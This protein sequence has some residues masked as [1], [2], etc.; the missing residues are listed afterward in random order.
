MHSKA[1]I[2]F[3]VSFYIYLYLVRLK[4]GVLADESA[5]MRDVYW[6]TNWVNIKKK[7]QI[8]IIIEPIRT[9]YYGNWYNILLTLYKVF[10]T[11][12]LYPKYDNNKF[13]KCFKFLAQS[14]D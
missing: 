3:I 6:H 1:N 9:S 10:S 14:I 8:K 13:F 2:Y 4:V 11:T 7:Q 5:S 12:F